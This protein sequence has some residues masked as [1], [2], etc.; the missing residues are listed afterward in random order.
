MLKTSSKLGSKTEEMLKWL[1]G[2]GGRRR[3]TRTRTRRRRLMPV[4]REALDR[5]SKRLQKL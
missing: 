1:L 2:K 3:R 5:R 4:T